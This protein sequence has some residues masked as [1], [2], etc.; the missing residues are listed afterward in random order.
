MQTENGGL[1]P[2]VKGVNL[3]FLRKTYHLSND[4]DI[5][6]HCSVISQLVS[7]S[8]LIVTFLY[9]ILSNCDIMLHHTSAVT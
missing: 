5:H 4:C 8:E 1:G 7:V 9:Y 6:V 3:V 2:P